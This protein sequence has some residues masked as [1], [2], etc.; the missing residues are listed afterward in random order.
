MMIRPLLSAVLILSLTGCVSVTE[1]PPGVTVDGTLPPDVNSVVIVASPAGSGAI[2]NAG[3]L[4]D[5]PRLFALSVRDALAKKR[6]DWRLRI[7][8]GGRD[9][10]GRDL[11]ITTQILDIDGGSAGLRFWIGFGA[12]AAEARARITVL[13]R[14]GK[15]IATAEISESA[16][17]PLGVCGDSNEEMIQAGLQRLAAD[18][19]EFIIDPAGYQQRKQ[20]R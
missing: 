1:A 18:A 13:G 7:D 12:G 9:T 4:T 8:E 2:R 5:V 15:P 17:C 20:A 16:I 11:T 3:T 10:A 6:P 14:A 19:A